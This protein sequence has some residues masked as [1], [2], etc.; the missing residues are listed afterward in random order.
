MADLKKLIGNALNK[1]KSNKPSD[2]GY[3]TRKVK[4]MTPSKMGYGKVEKGEKIVK[5]AESKLEKSVVKPYE[6]KTKKANSLKEKYGEYP[7]YGQEK[8]IQK[9]APN[10]TERIN[11]ER[12][13]SAKEYGQ[14]PSE[15]NLRPEKRTL[16][17]D[18]TFNREGLTSTIKAGKT[19]IKKGTMKSANIRNKE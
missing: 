7:T 12:M 1:A 10:N 19:L 18:K 11:Y 13:Q 2:D 8:K 16:F 9:A 15:T 14:S 4:G 3:A 5:R 6:S 17:S